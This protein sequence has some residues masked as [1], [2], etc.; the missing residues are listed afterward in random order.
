MYRL[1]QHITGIASN[2]TSCSV[3]KE[4]DKKRF[5]GPIEEGKGKKKTNKKK[6]EMRFKLHLMRKKMIVLLDWLKE[7]T[8]TWFKIVRKYPLSH[9]GLLDNKHSRCSL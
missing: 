4:E 9:E 7:A 1:K 8:R 2:I 5:K 3:A 6:L